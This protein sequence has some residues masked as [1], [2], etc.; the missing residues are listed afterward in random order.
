MIVTCS[1]AGWFEEF[2]RAEANKIL[3]VAFDRVIDEVLDVVLN[4]P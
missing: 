2:L 1:M 3:D 4:E